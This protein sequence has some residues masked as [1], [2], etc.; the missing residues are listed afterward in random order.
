M[1]V[2][3]NINPTGHYRYCICTMCFGVHMNN[4]VDLPDRALEDGI[5]FSL[6]GL[7]LAIS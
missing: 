2:I 5:L 3:E 4:Y 6:L 7:Y 1:R